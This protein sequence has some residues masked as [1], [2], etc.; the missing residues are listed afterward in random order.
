MI[1]KLFVSKYRPSTLDDLIVPK[2]IKEFLEKG[3][4][5]NVLFHGTNGIGKTSAARIISAGHATKYINI[6]DESSV[7]TI[8]TTIEAFCSTTSLE[9]KG[10]LK[11]VILDEI[12]G[13]SE[14]FFKALK[15]T[16]E[17]FEKTSRF[18][19]IS[20]HPS[21]IPVESKDRFVPIN[22]NI[23]DAE[24]EKEVKLSIARKVQQICSENDIQIERSA[25][26][27]F[28]EMNFPSIRT[29]TG[30]IEHWKVRDIKVVK[31]EEIIKLNYVFDDLYQKIF[32]ECSSWDLQQFFQTNYSTKVDDVLVAFR[33]DF[34]NWIKHNHPDKLEKVLDTIIIETC[35]HQYMRKFVIDPIITPMSLMFL[36][37]RS[38]K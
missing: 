35:K 8:R 21:K 29:M 2:R 32:S 36:I 16:V 27:K 26:I 20:N 25:L 30:K 18:I 23:L 28:V 12:D 5:Q 11:V 9:S 13:A 4:V 17:R 33:D 31:D 1:D 10:K 15:A 22:F 38:L 34:I 7:D 37:R 6:S 3:I 14:Q 24:E 19:A